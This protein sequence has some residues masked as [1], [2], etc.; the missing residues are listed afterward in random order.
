MRGRTR[1]ADHV[2]IPVGG[3]SGCSLSTSVSTWQRA[4]E[5][6]IPNKVARIAEQ[7]GELDEVHDASPYAP[8]FLEVPSP[9]ELKKIYGKFFKA[10]SNDA[11]ATRTCRVC[12]REFSVKEDA[13]QTIKLTDMPNTACL[14][15]KKSHPQHQLRKDMLLV[16]SA[17]HQIVYV[18]K[19][20][21]KR[22][23]GVRDVSALQNA[24]NAGGQSDAVPAN[25]TGIIDH[26]HIC[27]GQTP[28][29]ELASNDIPDDI[30]VEISSIIRQTDDVGIVEQE[31]EGYIPV[32][33]DELKVSG[34]V[35]TEMSSI[36]AWEMIVWGLSNLWEEG[37]EGAYAVR[38][39]D[40]P[41]GDFG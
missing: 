27:G 5:T 9:G 26:N 15:P 32:D 35:D 10:T 13:V 6:D 33:N 30:L 31:G 34:T 37:G 24:I 22:T 1:L 28:T 14:H 23:G 11:L 7:L 39:G 2:K 4:E 40:W 3:L 38:H 36:T 17:I 25:N 18:F 8:G 41:V 16:P 21:P 12:A 20:F 19:L 29:Q